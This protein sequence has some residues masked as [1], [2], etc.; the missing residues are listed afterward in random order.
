[1]KS[2]HIPRSVLTIGKACFEFTTIESLTFE[3]GSQLRLFDES[4]FHACSLKLICIPRS[5]EVIG[6][7]CFYGRTSWDYYYHIGLQ[8]IRLLVFE[9]E[10][11]LQR[12]EHYYFHYSRLESILIPRSVEI[13]GSNYFLK[14]EARTIEF[15]ADSRL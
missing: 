2:I 8:G 13:L 3:P 1:V 4:C 7:K 10:S 5:V 12:I 15:E 14:A 9:S 6:P 11:Y